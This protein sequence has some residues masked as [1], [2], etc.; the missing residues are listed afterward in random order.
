MTV[1]E[2]QHV[3]GRRGSARARTRPARAPASASVS[4]PGTGPV[5]TVQ[6]RPLRA[7]GPDLGGREALELAVLPLAQVGID[8]GVGEAASRAVSRARAAGLASTSANAW[9]ASR[10][11]SATAAARPASVSGT[12]VRLVWRPALAPLRRTVANQPDVG[13]HRRILA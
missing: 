5:H 11:A 13:F 7:P 8:L 9:P 6:S 10:G 3:A 12:S 1:P 4:P 2:E